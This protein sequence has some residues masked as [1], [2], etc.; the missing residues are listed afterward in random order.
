MARK[1][2]AC[3]VHTEQPKGDAQQRGDKEMWS[4]ASLLFVDQDLTVKSRV[5]T[6]SYQ[7]RHA[8]LKVRV[9]KL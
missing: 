7:K 9:I 3:I 2:A 6:K 1:K 4:L 8:T 5:Q